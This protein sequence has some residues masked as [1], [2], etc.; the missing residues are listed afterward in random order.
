MR[1]YP[2]WCRGCAFCLGACNCKAC[3]RQQAAYVAPRCSEPQRAELLEY[4]LRNVA[5]PVAGLLAAM[6]A[7]VSAEAAAWIGIVVFS[8]GISMLNLNKNV[9]AAVPFPTGGP[10]PVLFPAIDALPAL[11]AHLREYLTFADAPFR[12]RPPTP[13]QAGREGRRLEDV[14][15]NALDASDRVLCDLC[16]NAIPDLH[17]SCAAC[18]ADICV[19]CCREGHDWAARDGSA[20][21]GNG[22]GDGAAGS[23][24]AAAASARATG[25][26]NGGGGRAGGAPAGGLLEWHRATRA[27]CRTERAPV[28][29]RFLT[30][31]D[32]ATLRRV[33]ADYSAA[34]HGSGAA[35]AGAA[36]AAGAPGGGAAAVAPRCAAPPVAV[37]PGGFAARAEH[38]GAAPLS[39]ACLAPPR[40]GGAA[41]RAAPPPHPPAFS[42]SQVSAVPRPAWAAGLPASDLRLAAASPAAG[43]PNH[44][45]A[46]AAAQLQP[47]HPQFASSHAQFQQRWAAGE[48]VIVRGLKSRMMWT[49]EVRR[50]H[51]AAQYWRRPLSQTL[52]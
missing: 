24:A 2:A 39:D 50:L 16:A 9:S 30:N 7:E 43:A 13:P 34:S 4:L 47:G 45:Y 35:A 11:R 52:R 28:L 48:P 19:A 26:G 31:A 42:A 12:Y 40:S 22:D 5:G 3:L 44:L 41:A 8:F 17:R 46:P 14:P 1:P 32:L 49:P 20:S 51:G 27:G 21:G 33:V 29:R 37:L 15:V 25:G 18:D 10:S 36:S 38:L 6:D 23:G